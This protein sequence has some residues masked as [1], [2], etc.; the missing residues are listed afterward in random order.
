MKQTEI[1]HMNKKAE[2]RARKNRSKLFVAQ[3]NG[4][5]NIRDA[6][7]IGDIYLNDGNKLKHFCR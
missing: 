6:P 7:Y 4:D 2:D 5:V 1:N 3:T